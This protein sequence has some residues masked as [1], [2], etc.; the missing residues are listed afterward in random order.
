MAVIPL[1]VTEPDSDSTEPA[2]MSRLNSRKESGR[3]A[4]ASTRRD[5]SAASTVLKSA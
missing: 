5:L 3:C 2:A 4:S 1:E